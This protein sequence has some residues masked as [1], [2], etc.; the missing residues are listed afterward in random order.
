LRN[1]IRLNTNA[2]LQ[3][4]RRIIFH[5]P[6]LLARSRDKV[7]LKDFIMDDDFGI[8]DMLRIGSMLKKRLHIGLRWWK[9]SWTEAV[10]MKGNPDAAA[11]M[12][13]ISEP[14]RP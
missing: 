12:G 4:L 1:N 9:D 13:N 14:T 2:W 7:S 5:N 6:Q 3:Y 8:D 11:S 10:A